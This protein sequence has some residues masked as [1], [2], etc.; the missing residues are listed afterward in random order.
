[1]NTNKEQILFKRLF[2]AFVFMW[3]YLKKH[4]KKFSLSIF[5]ML[6]VAGTTASYAYIVKEVLDKWDR[7]FCTLYSRIN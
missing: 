2:M 4:I 1:M 7:D 5:L 3:P 6:V